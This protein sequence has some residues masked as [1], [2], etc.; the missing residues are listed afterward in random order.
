MKKFIKTA[1]LV[2]A[3]IMVLIQFIPSGKKNISTTAQPNS[4]ENTIQVPPNILSDLK[5]GC[6]D[7]H[8][9]N[10]IYPWYS[11]IQPAAWWLNSHIVEG[12]EHLNFDEFATLDEEGRSEMLEEIGEVIE[13]HEMPLSS[14]TLL[15]PKA[16]FSEKNRLIITSWISKNTNKD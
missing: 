9:N 3:G 1:F 16:R 7:C 5:N 2:F 12:K 10:T 6:Y 11:N 13:E 4:M 8:S 15:H 14:Y